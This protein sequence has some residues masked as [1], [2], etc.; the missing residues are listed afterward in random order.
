MKA[1]GTDRGGKSLRLLPP[2]GTRLA[3]ERTQLLLADKRLV[4]GLLRTG[5]AVIALP[6][7]VLAALAIAPPASH[8]DTSLIVL[9][10]GLCA[11]VAALGVFLIGRALQQLAA[12]ERRM[13]G[14][15]RRS[16]PPGTPDAAEA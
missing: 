11:G 7:L 3:I 8:L 14:L 5:A 13:A 15:Q 2:G 4:L 6:L 12:L 9:L 1:P 16:A 10:V